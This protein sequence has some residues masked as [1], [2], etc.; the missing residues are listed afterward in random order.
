MLAF[1][2]GV[3]MGVV[4][5]HLLNLLAKA[6]EDLQRQSIKRA[7]DEELKNRKK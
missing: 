3:A 4:L 5:G 1:Y 2:L 6:I 7:I